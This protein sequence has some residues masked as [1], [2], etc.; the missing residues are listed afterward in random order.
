MFLFTFWFAASS[1]ST[2]SAN[3]PLNYQFPRRAYLPTPRF[4]PHFVTN[5]EYSI[6]GMHPSKSQSR[7]SEWGAS[8]R[9]RKLSSYKVWRLTLT[10]I[11]FLQ[12]LSRYLWGSLQV[13]I[14]GT[15]LDLLRIEHHWKIFFLFFSSNLVMIFSCIQQ[16]HGTW[17]WVKYEQASV[18]IG[19]K[20]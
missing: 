6:S 9:T 13:T 17:K 10:G 20:S 7:W 3:A 19:C 5:S 14:T 12:T 1:R 15:N 2:L 16:E 18:L 8:D 11:M 4:I